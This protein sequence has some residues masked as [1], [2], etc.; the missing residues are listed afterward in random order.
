MSTT[1]SPLKMWARENISDIV[2]W[3]LGEDVVS[4]H[5]ENVE[6]TLDAPPRIDLVFHLELADK[7]TCLF[8]LEFQGRRSKPPI[9]RRQLNHLLRLPLR[10]EWPVLIESFVLYVEKYAGQDDNGRHQLN[11]LDGTAAVAWNYTPIHLWREPADSILALDRVGIIPLA[12]LMDIQEPEKTLPEIAQR[13]QAEPNKEKRVS[14]FTSLLALI[15]DEEHIRMLDALVES[16]EFVFN[17]PFLQRIRREAAEE[18]AQE[19]WQKGLQEGVQEGFLDASYAYIM[20]I[21]ATRF[22][23]PISTYLETE[24]RIRLIKEQE[25]LDKWFTAVLQAESMEEF[26][27]ALADAQSQK[28]SK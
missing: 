2:G 24:R 25:E 28:Q 20:K 7:R 21:F 9:P 5:E 6:L 27:A 19:G 1:D 10:Y 26:T 17:S 8:H 23:P 15:S 3:L 22:D 14:L 16:D 13:I 18:A 11:R 12:A 4:I